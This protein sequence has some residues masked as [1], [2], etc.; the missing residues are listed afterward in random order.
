MVPSG[1]A[2]CI[3]RPLSSAVERLPYKQDVAGSKPAA[4]IT[5]K[6]WDDW[7][8][9]SVPGALSALCPTCHGKSRKACARSCATGDRLPYGRG[10]WPS[11]GRHPLTPPTMNTRA[12]WALPLAL[13]AAIQPAATAPMPASSHPAGVLLIDRCVHTPFKQ[14]GEGRLISTYTCPNSDLVGYSIAVDCARYL[15]NLHAPGGPL[16]VDD[17][18]RW[19]GWAKPADTHQQAAMDVACDPMFKTAGQG[20][21]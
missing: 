1:Q 15:V 20:V 4:G 6:A 9:G 11:Q 14:Q 17:A 12:L 5:Q 18:Y 19:H 13:A 2:E 21:R 8:L 3:Y 16:G 10:P 7:A